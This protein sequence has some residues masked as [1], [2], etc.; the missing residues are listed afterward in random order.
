MRF[1]A[2]CE[3][4]WERVRGGDVECTWNEAMTS[5]PRG[6]RFRSHRACAFRQNHVDS[7]IIPAAGGLDEDEELCGVTLRSRLQIVPFI[8][9]LAQF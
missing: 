7:Q 9:I 6:F 2:L 1:C 8:L 5:W 4:Q 3:A